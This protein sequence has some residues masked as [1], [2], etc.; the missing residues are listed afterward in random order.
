M[1][2]RIE[3]SSK[4]MGGRQVRTDKRYGNIFDHHAVIYTYADGT[5]MHSYCRQIPNCSRRVAE[6][7]EGTE[8]IAELGSSA[9]ALKRHGGDS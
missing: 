5:Q 9:C 8:G 4:G 2:N 1:S 3:G 6:E 7:I